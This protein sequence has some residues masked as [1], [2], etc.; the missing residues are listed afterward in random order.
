MVSPRS[1]IWLVTLL[2]LEFSINSALGQTVRAYVDRNPISMDET[3][4]LVVELKGPST[5][6]TPDLSGLKKNFD[7]L[8]NSQ[9]SQ[10]S[11]INGRTSTSTQWAITLS[12]KQVGDVT[13]PAIRVGT[14]SSAPLTL[15]VQEHAQNTGDPA[16]KDVYLEASI[17]PREPY[18]QSQM[19]F[20]LRLYHAVLLREGQLEDPKISQAIVERIGED[21]SF[22]TI[23]NGRRYQVIERRYL[24]IPQASGPLT[25]PSVLFT[26]KVPDGRRPRSMFEEMFGNRPGVFGSGF[27][28]TRLIRA[29]SQE[30]TLNVEEIPPT[31]QQGSW[32]PAR[33]LSVNETWSSDL[34]KLQVGEP[35]TRTITI[36]ARGLTGE[37]L[38][39]VPVTEHSSVKVYPDQPS[40]TTAFDGSWAVGKREQKLAFVPT[41][42]GDVL[43]PEIRI[44]WWNLET[45]KPEE[46]VLPAQTLTIHGANASEPSAQPGNGT[47]SIVNDAQSSSFLSEGQG[48][49]QSGNAA[50]SGSLGMSWPV[51]MGLLLALWLLT[52]AGWWGDRRKLMM[53]QNRIQED[54]QKSH[55]SIRMIRSLVKQ[56]CL[57]NKPQQAREA[58]LRWASVTWEGSGH[59]NLGSVARK[60][61]QT[62][63]GASAAQ[64]AIQD[65]DRTLYSAKAGE[66]NGT[67]FWETIAPEMQALEKTK[68]TWA[69]K[70]DDVAPLY[71]HASS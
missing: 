9:S 3:V 55:E 6:E 48:L 58:L 41:R 70:E 65:L 64:Q 56:A 52:A 29:R 37:Q 62:T 25:I 21:H 50:S 44:R 35:V 49:P 38:P 31:M 45:K 23:Q 51:M 14:Q 63:Q 46:A 59:R 69:A 12:P 20:T 30:M 18:V 43:L 67:R 2:L 68:G 60:F 42:P 1:C 54:K 17:E 16:G 36:Q 22:E 57:Q 15:R 66:W 19:V 27:Q 47:T 7:V 39:E 13:I 34:T 33:E 61:G 5:G 53:Q 71:L 26:G 4:R 24:V 8:E 32:L 40:I 11:I 28:S 10:T